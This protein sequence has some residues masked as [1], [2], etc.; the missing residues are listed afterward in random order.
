MD[1]SFTSNAS[2]MA[3]AATITVDGLAA[4]QQDVT[5]RLLFFLG[6][7][8]LDTS[9][10]VPYYTQILGKSRPQA[11]RSK[12]LRKVVLGTAGIQSLIQDLSWSYNTATRQ[13]SVSFIASTT[14]GPLNYNETMVI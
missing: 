2:A 14:S 10:G 4:I 3:Q 1:F 7:W 12:I 8:F 13:A 6:E 5:R 9:Q 11:Q